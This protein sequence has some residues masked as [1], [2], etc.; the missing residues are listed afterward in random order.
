M[1]LMSRVGVLSDL[2]NGDPP[3]DS[4]AKTAILALFPRILIVRKDEDK[5][6]FDGI[7]LWDWQTAAAEQE[8]REDM[9]AKGR[10]KRGRRK[11][12][13]TVNGVLMSPT[14]LRGPPFL[15]RRKTEADDGSG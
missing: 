5:T 13:N 1:T 10:P 14:K 12:S 6:L 4:L 7:G 11:M 3:E 9:E 8:L 15:G 2:N